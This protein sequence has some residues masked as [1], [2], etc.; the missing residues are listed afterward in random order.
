MP[1]A[2][3]AAA[4]AAGFLLLPIIIGAAMDSL[5][6]QQQQAGLLASSYFAGYFVSCVAAVFLIKRLSLRVLA[7]SGYVFLCAGL[8]AAALTVDAVMLGFCM[9][10]SG[11]G[12]G[13]LFGLAVLIA[14]QGS[15]SERDFGILLVS[16]QLLAVALLYVL[17]SLIVP[18]WGFSGIMIALA[19]ILGPG[20][21]TV[22][23]LEYRSEDQPPSSPTQ[24]P[25][26]ALFS[27]NH[28]IWFGLAGLTVYFAALAGVWAFVERMGVDRGLS[29][30]WI[31]IS[32][33][34]SMIGGVIGGLLVALL[35]NRFGRSRPLVLSLAAFVGVFV[36]YSMDYGVLI[37][38]VSTFMFSLFWNY[39]LGYQ[40]VI[41]SDL[42]QAGRYAV[43]IPAAQALGAVLGPGM[44]GFIIAGL[45]YMPFF[46]AAALALAVTTG[47]FLLIAPAGKTS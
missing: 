21:L 40:M 33:S 17:P 39:V 11:F 23:R 38:A 26:L 5:G 22:F 27:S 2:I 16:Q 14:G 28:S 4:G 7:K 31:S 9:L 18:H 10:A 29:S 25:G 19:L 47:F 32:L 46:L 44:A 41:I 42:D 6:L 20:V 30:Q 12:A 15:N 13:L 3:M 35:A 37:Y 1:A 45:G 8:L 34:L 24:N 43:L 36:A